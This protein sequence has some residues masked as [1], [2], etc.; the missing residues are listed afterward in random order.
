LWSSA[1]AVDPKI[2][3]LLDM[4]TGV[5]ATVFGLTAGALKSFM[6]FRGHQSGPVDRAWR[7]VPIEA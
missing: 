3:A 7:L 1:H 4:G 2:Q 5:P 6:G